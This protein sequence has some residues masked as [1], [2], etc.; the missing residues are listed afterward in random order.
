MKTIQFIFRFLLALGLG[1]FYLTPIYAQYPD[2]EELPVRPFQ[3]SLVYPLSTSGF[4]AGQYYHALSLNM[5]AGYHGGLKGMEIGGV[6]NV[7]KQD[8]YG[9]QIA[10]V[11]NVVGRDLKGLQTAGAFNLVAGEV[12]GTQIAGVA[13]LSAKRAQATQ[14]A[15][16]ANL[17][18]GDSQG[19]QVAGVANLSTDRQKGAQIAGV[20]NYAGT[21]KGL[22]IGVI[23][24]ADTLEGGVQVGVFSYA[25]YGGMKQL[26]VGI[27][28]LG[29]ASLTVRTGSPILY[30]IYGVGYKPADQ[31][32]YWTVTL[33]LGT[34]I[35][36]NRL[37][38]LNLEA[39]AQHLNE[40]S[41]WENRLQELYRAQAQVE[42]AVSQR[43]SIY[44]GVAW[45]TLVTENINK[46]SFFGTTWGEAAVFDRTVNGRTRV[47]MKPGFQG[48]V[49]VN[50]GRRISMDEKA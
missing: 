2:G 33:G 10:G 46:E 35:P 18:T 40:G 42:V 5:T 12:K 14:V 38:A 7:I 41:R 44:G 39:T 13:N 17:S 25:K 31:D 19:M 22:Q 49:R 50:L 3:L 47:L 20:L 23:N 21:L 6:A 32:F 36:L 8:V 1:G 34:H 26:D 30:N 48:G 45:N 9:L 16:V 24:Y 4:T 37:I 29:I 15:G 27:N 28:E 11:V 43:L